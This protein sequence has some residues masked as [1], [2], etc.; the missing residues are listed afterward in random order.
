MNH[1]ASHVEALND[2]IQINRDRVKGYER[3]IKDLQETYSP[4]TIEKF[5]MYKQDSERFVSE[6]S[7]Q[8]RMFAGEPAT[9]STIGGTIHRAWMDLKT[10][11]SIHQKEAALESCIFGDEAAIKAYESVLSNEDHPVP[12][13]VA[14]VL[15]TQLASI[16]GAQN[17]NKAHEKNLEMTNH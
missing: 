15:N 17:A 2:L 3:A 7:Q 9:T 11:L 14:A 10:S 5:R 1:Q 6:L 8:V 4:A 12:G 16:R 13:T